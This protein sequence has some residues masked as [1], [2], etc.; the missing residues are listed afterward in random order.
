MKIEKYIVLLLLAINMIGCEQNEP[1][2]TVAL[3]ISICL[4][5]SEVH[6]TGQNSPRRVMGDPGTFETFLFPHYLYIVVMKQKPDESWEVWEHIE[7]TL[8]NA[9][10]KAEPYTGI[11]PTPGDSIYRYKEEINL[12]LSTGVPG[13]RNEFKGRV[14]A[15][16]SAKALDLSKSLE[17]ISGLDD[18][19]ALTFDA[20]DADIQNNLQHIYSSPYNLLDEGE[21]YG[22]FS[23]IAQRVPNVRLLLYHVAAKVDITWRTANSSLRLTHMKAKNLFNGNAYCFKPMDN[24]S[25][26]PLASGAEITI[27]GD[28][29]VGQWWEGRTYFY[30]I[31]YTTTGKAGYFPLQMEMSTNGSSNKYRPTIYMQV[32]TSDPFVPWL[33]ANFNINAELDDKTDEKIVTY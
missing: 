16:A 15:I 9:D 20:S 21:Y 31:P 18:L 24:S 13:E 12:T 5:A 29:A 8:T 22:A 10:W 6:S 27:I 4:P 23:S 26:T 25:A 11:F 14:Y 7:R 19:L 1:K 17:S 28:N 32:D 30:T 33:R 3:P 2:Q